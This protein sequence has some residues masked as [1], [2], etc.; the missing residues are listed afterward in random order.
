MS[1]ADVPE[2][3]W[4]RVREATGE[5]CGYCLSPQR[6]VMDK[7]EIEHLV[8]RAHSGGGES[9]LWLS[10]SLC[11]RDK[12]SRVEVAYPLTGSVEPPYNPRANNWHEHLRWSANPTAMGRA[13]V[14]SQ[15]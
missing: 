7:L 3:T 15:A 14:A 13:T 9:T 8:L 4:Q 2:V 5:W 11:N 1:G 6:L 10:C 12:G